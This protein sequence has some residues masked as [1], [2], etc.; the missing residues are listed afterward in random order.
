M[1]NES[2][3]DFDEAAWHSRLEVAQTSDDFLSLLAELPPA[4][5]VSDDEIIQRFKGETSWESIDGAE[6]LLGWCRFWFVA[7]W[8]L[9]VEQQARCIARLMQEAGYHFGQELEATRLNKNLRRWYAGI[10]NYTGQKFGRCWM[11]GLLDFKSER[12]SA[13]KHRFSR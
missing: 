5:P 1:Y 2:E 9:P 6:S 3:P 8:C 13:R 4:K 7:E 10:L 12:H 11:L